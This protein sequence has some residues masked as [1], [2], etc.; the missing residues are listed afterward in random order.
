M[1][2]LQKSLSL[3]LAYCKRQRKKILVLLLSSFSSSLLSE[4]LTVLG[5]EKVCI[6]VR[7]MTNNKM[8]N[9]E[10]QLWLV[11]WLVGPFG[12][13]IPHFPGH[14]WRCPAEE[15]SPPPGITVPIMEAVDSQGW[16]QGPH[17]EWSASNHTFLLRVLLCKVGLLT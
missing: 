12:I 4:L 8:T 17:C 3:C 11:R 15:W 14:W 16:S 7:G 5:T 13:V 10:N 6:D 1:W 2:G 9:R